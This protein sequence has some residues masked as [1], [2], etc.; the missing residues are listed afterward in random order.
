VTTTN[1][2]HLDRISVVCVPV[3]DQDRSIEFYVDKLGF[4]KRVDTPF[5]DQYRWV[6]V[7]PPSGTTGIALAPPRP[8]DAVTPRDTGISLATDDIDASHSE[9]Q[10][11]G[12]DIDAEVSRMGGPVPPLVWFRDPDGHT[13]MIVEQD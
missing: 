10:S 13:L 1:K 7:Y 3:S 8:G 6:E 4:E 12:V 9:L 2:T 11:A 5:G